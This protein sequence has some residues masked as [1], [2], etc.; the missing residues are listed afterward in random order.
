MVSAIITTAQQRAHHCDKITNSYE[1]GKSSTILYSFFPTVPPN[2]KIVE[3][4]S[5][6]T[7]LPKE[8]L[9]IDS[10]SF[11]LTDDKG[12]RLNM[13]GET[14]TNRISLKKI[15]LKLKKNASQKISQKSLHIWL[16]DVL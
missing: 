12:R 8:R 6:P 15:S 11:W 4:P 13:R 2:F 1:N 7:Y 3:I 9:Y 5:P 10:I 14:V 16:W